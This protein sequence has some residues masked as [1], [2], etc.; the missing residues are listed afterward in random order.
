[1]T[2]AAPPSVPDAAHDSATTPQ[3][4]RTL[5]HV[6]CAPGVHA[7]PGLAA[8]IAAWPTL[9]ETVRATMLRLIETGEVR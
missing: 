7:D 4:N 2:D 8:V 3:L 6:L 1:M 9:S 5:P